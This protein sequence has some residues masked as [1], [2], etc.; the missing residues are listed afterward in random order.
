M[1]EAIW[2][3]WQPEVVIKSI[4]AKAMVN[5]EKACEMIVIKIQDSMM[6][7]KSGL[8]YILE[9]IGSHQASAPG[10][11]PAFRYGELYDNVE[12]RIEDRGD[13]LVGVIGVNLD[14]DDIGY[15]M[16][17]EIGTKFMEQRPYIRSTVF[18]NE[19]EILKILG[20]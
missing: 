16:Y 8:I 13:E 17:L 18:E 3:Y 2:E 12:Y 10:E 15:A 19:S 1:R 20:A 5:L 14:S 11:S 9:G 4:K 7:S 6:E